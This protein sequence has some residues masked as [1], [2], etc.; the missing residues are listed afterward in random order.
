MQYSLLIA[1]TKSGSGKTSLSLALLA[2]L[3]KRGL[4]VQACKVGPDFIDPSHHAA[5]TH[6]PSYNLDAWMGEDDGLKRVYARMCAQAQKNKA[7][8]L[9]AEGVMGLF[10]GAS[11]VGGPGSSAHVA[12]LLQMPVLLVVDV[13]GMGQSAVAVATGFTRLQKHIPFAG[14]VCSHVG[15][16]SHINML[17]EAFEKEL[18]PN[19][20][21]IWG[22]LPRKGHIELKSRHLGLHM[23]HEY[24]WDEPRLT[25]M[26]AWVEEHINIDKLLTYCA[27]FPSVHI[28]PKM[29][30]RVQAVKQTIAIARDA[31]FC[32]LYPDMADV[33][34]EMGAK[35]VYFSPLNDEEIPENCTAIYL[36]GG[37]PEL[38]GAK[39]AQNT[40]TLNSIR[41]FANNGGCVYAECGGFIY[42]MKD[43]E[44]AGKTHQLCNVLPISAHMAENK[45]ALGYRE[46]YLDQERGR[47]HEFHY[48]KTTIPAHVP[49]LWNVFDRQHL[50]INIRETAGI[51]KDNIMASW[52]H[53]YPE[54]S[55]KLLAKIFSLSAE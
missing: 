48:A 16:E 12:S 41:N 47:G 13:R 23:G 15:S 53:L 38:Y 27:K 43:L 51:K 31:A 49:P 28:M 42:L 5:I 35:C 22:Y 2:A 25:A 52:V 3:Q 26:A 32:F 19:D 1:G 10:D 36:P 37:Y 14:I 40:N 34:T 29:S 46:V 9:L 7:H 50:P 30:E 11:S 18:G 6:N 55:R 21:P 4:K 24:T 54:G 45:T 20:P 33:L 39:L 17:K 44:Y 8:M